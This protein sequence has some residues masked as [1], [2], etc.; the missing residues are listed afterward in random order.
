MGAVVGKEMQ[1]ESELF[2]SFG[3]ES[4]GHLGVRPVVEL[5]PGVT[6]STMHKL[7]D[8]PREDWAEN[9]N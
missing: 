6:E 9:N 4:E 5:S 7:E 2:N 8:Q 1:L 3:Y